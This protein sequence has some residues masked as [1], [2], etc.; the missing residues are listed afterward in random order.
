MEKLLFLILNKKIEIIFFLQLI[1]LILFEKIFNFNL[2]LIYIIITIELLFLILFISKEIFFIK[3]TIFISFGFVYIIS[4]ISWLT[5]DFN[6][7]FFYLYS[8][9]S[10][11]YYNYSVLEYLEKLKDV[12]ILTLLSAGF[13]YLGYSSILKKEKKQ[14]NNR[15]NKKINLIIFFTI[16]SILI[17]INIIFYHPLIQISLII[18]YTFIIN[19]K[20]SKIIRLIFLLSIFVPTIL[21]SL[22]N[23]FTSR[24]YFVYIYLLATYLINKKKK[25]S[26]PF[27]LRQIIYFMIYYFLISYYVDR[28]R[29]DGSVF[30]TIPN[31]E[32]VS[33]NLTD[34]KVFLTPIFRTLN[35]S[36]RRL[37]QSGSLFHY[38]D[39]IMDYDFLKINSQFHFNILYY[40]NKYLPYFFNKN[41][42]I[43]H[44]SI[45]FGDRIWN[46][47]N[48]TEIDSGHIV[49]MI[50]NFGHLYKYFF[51]GYFLL[52]ILYAVFYEILKTKY[53]EYLIFLFFY[54]KAF[55]LPENMLGFIIISIKSF[56]IFL[57]IN[58]LICKKINLLNI[59]K[60]KWPF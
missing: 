15:L 39:I 5:F 46:K 58:Y 51:I 9:S 27:F 19:I 45:N 24:G 60:I 11:Y 21:S 12:F 22:L 56:F 52:G 1:N 41:Y 31:V 32:S 43:Q 36:F 23:I 8:Y 50:S 37:D 25:L 34:T 4:H 38:Y 29:N 57:L 2:L 54:L 30:V 18:A 35:D 26:P 44:N 53:Y 47:N 6:K 3:F 14:I 17:F 13:F 59:K 16:F 10:E 49:S 48:A 28:Y 7:I 20:S 33:I 42:E 55:L 40:L